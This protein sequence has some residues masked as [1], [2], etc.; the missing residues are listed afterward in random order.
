MPAGAPRGQRAPRAQSLSLCLLAALAFMAHGSARSQALKPGD[1]MF[2]TYNTQQDGWALVALVDL[3][4]GA[5]VYFTDNAW[6]PVSGFAPGGGFERW[7][8]GPA[9][10]AAGTVVRFSFV[11]D[12]LSLSASVGSLDRVVVPGSAYLNLSQT[13][14]TLYAYLGDSATQATGFLTAVSNA[15]SASF[16]SALS[17]TGLVAGSNALVLPAGAQFAEYSATRRQS[18]AADGYRTL[19]SNPGNW[20]AQTGGAYATQVASAAPLNVLAV[21]EADGLWMLAAGA[22]T[23]WAARRAAARTARQDRVGAIR[24]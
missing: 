14:G 7:V 1:L 6:N 22:L 9:R 16:T 13:S 24:L 10:I 19:L 20:T 4:P 15:G 17:G 2:S 18:L 8:S 5:T 3:A 12:P 11:D 23:L 21:P